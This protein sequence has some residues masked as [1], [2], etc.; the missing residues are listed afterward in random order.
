MEIPKFS[1]Y[2]GRFNKFCQCLLFWL[3]VLNFLLITIINPNLLNPGPI[4]TNNNVQTR[5]LKIFYNNV[6]GLINPRDLRSDSPPLNMTK[7]FELQDFIF[8]HKPDIVVINESWLKSSI[9]NSEILPENSYKIIRCDRSGKT[10]P[11][12]PSQPKKFRKH[13]GGVFIAH[14]KDI[15][16]ESTE[17]GLVKVQAE[18]L[19]VNF[20]LPSGKCF[21]LSTFYRVG[22][23]G[24]ENFDLVKNY[25]I[26]LASKK[27]L[28]KHL[29]IGDLNFPEIAWPDNSTTVELHR[30]FIDFY[31]KLLT[32][33]IFIK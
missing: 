33:P 13:G 27:K 6:Q 10:H 24:T 22:T 5:P 11:W 26:T 14:R 2:S 7:L 9:L 15:G 4:R 28:N 19:T 21:S 18:I 25:L 31:R 12:D 20:K 3:C 30:K 23:L 1:L 29:L 17:V 16:I 32:D 8:K